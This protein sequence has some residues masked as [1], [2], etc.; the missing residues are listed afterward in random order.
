V[1]LR[2]GV[3]MHASKV[4]EMAQKLRSEKRFDESIEKYKELIAID[5]TMSLLAYNE[6]AMMYAVEGKLDAAAQ[7]FKDA[8]K[9]NDNSAAP[10]NIASIYLNLAI[11]LERSSQQ[12]QAA[13]FYELAVDGYKK[14]LAKNSNSVD[15][16]TKLATALAQKGDANEALIYFRKAVDMAPYDIRNHITLADYLAYINRDREAVD[17]L[18]KAIDFMRSANLPDSVKILEQTLAQIQAQKPQ[19]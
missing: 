12:A 10:I 19:K 1:V 17:T 7:T 3:E 6:I 9:Y 13:K 16:V 5:P 18:N 8:I 4:R 15:T 11:I 14:G 2:S